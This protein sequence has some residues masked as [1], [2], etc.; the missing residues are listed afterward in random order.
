MMCDWYSRTCR[1][2][3]RS[4][5]ICA[6]GTRAAACLISSGV[7]RIRSALKAGSSN[8]TATSTSAASP[9]RATSAITC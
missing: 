1:I 3:C 5:S 8:F 6:G 2:E 9:R 7:T 4:A